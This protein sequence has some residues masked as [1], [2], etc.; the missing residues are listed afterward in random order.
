MMNEGVKNVDQSKPTYPRA[1]T[2]E[3]AVVGVTGGPTPMNERVRPC[4]R[5]V[6]TLGV[7]AVKKGIREFILDNVMVDGVLVVVVG[8]GGN[9]N[10]VCEGVEMAGGGTAG[11]WDVV[12]TFFSKLLR[13]VSGGGASF[14]GAARARGVTELAINFVCVSDFDGARG[15][16]SRISATGDEGTGERT[17]MGGGRRF[18]FVT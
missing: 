12:F 8:E 2:F 6:D 3:N 16:S 18:F 5:K 11:C 7:A 10:N 15:A 1:S 4:N 14:R 17:L 13:K 9:T